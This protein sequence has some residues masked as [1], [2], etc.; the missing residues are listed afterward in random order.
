[1]LI[2]SDDLDYQLID[3]AFSAQKEASHNWVEL[4]RIYR[5]IV[6][7]CLL[8]D[9]KKFNRNV[10]SMPIA[11]DTVLI[12][13]SIFSSSFQIDNLPLSISKLGEENSEAARQLRIACAYYWQKADPFVELNKAM[14]RMLIFPIG[15]VFD[16]WDVQ[17]KRYVIEECN[18]TDVA[19]DYEA[20]NNNDVQYLVYRYRKSAKEIRNILLSDAKK[21]KKNRFYNKIENGHI[22]FFK[23]VYD[24]RTFKPFERYELKE[25]YIKESDGWLCKTYYPDGNLLLRVVKFKECPFKWG[26]MREKLSSV[27]DGLREKEI[28]VYGES[29]IDFIKEHV[30]LIN[31]RRNQHFDI[32]E[33]Q[34]NPSVYIGQGAKVNPAHLK[35]GAGSKIPVGDASQIKERRAPSTMGLHDDLALLKEDVETT[36]SVN[37]L[38]KAQTSAS[39]R[40]A[41]GAI[42]M[43]SSQA[44]TRIEEQIMTANRTLF[45]HV[46]K[47]F[48]KKVYRYVDSDTL[49]KL[50]IEEPVIGVDVDDKEDFDFVVSVQFGSDMKRDKIF[51][52][53]MQALQALGQ[54]NEVNPM[55][56]EKLIKGAMEAKLPDDFKV[57]DDLFNSS[58]SSN[59]EDNIEGGGV[60]PGI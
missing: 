54:F 58:D 24:K 4:E 60:E 30:K 43:L 29:E 31:Q 25:I 47:S 5:N 7:E 39:D 26:F 9:A 40:R 49:I 8:E 6:D 14:L 18:P 20:R 10:V 13:R 50:G 36:T 11:R 1:M 45:S 22:E 12:K 32:V 2:E 27:D 42:A 41:T 44:S 59:I 57:D 55:Y 53:Y 16:Y 21:K 56:I 48:V 51:N 35:R 28:M 33:E 38:Y 23:T 19:F 3:A 34:I 46:A 17:R 15:I 37:G 52:T